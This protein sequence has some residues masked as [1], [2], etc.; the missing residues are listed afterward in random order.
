MY[1]VVYIRLG[2]VENDKYCIEV[3][4]EVKTLYSPVVL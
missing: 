1:K 4:E 3:L 2:L